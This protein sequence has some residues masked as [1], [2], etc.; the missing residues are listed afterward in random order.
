[1]GHAPISFDEFQAK[2]IDEILALA[3]TTMIYAA[4]GTRRSAVL[5]GVSST[6]DEY[7]QW[8]YNQMI[9]C[10]E[11][12]FD[13]GVRNIITHAITPAQYDEVTEGYRE[14]LLEWVDWV[15]AGP[16]AIKGYESRRWR[17]RLLGAEH[18]P[19]LEAVVNR[20][21]Q[22]SSPPDAPTLWLTVTPTESASWD[23]IIGA[24]RRSSAK[25][26]AEAIK[27]QFGEEIEPATL[28]IGSGKPSVFPAI[29][30]PLLMG[31]TQCY[32]P[33]RPG[34]IV[35]PVTVRKILYDYAYTR[36]TWQKD[37]SGRAEKVLEDT[38]LWEN[39]PILGLGTRLG[40][41]WYPSWKEDDA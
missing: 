34:F 22:I 36:K 26:Q 28:F 1:M 2:P 16:E 19:A 11:I 38:D 25:T 33:L 20:L 17:V 23:S 5:A 27:A 7:A 24:I 31:K 41:F 35:E 4:G 37:K 13:H 14:K 3:P 40:P 12:F 30:P 15:L 6:G 39:A 18:L 9:S 32:W 21:K 29:V 10:F 8:A